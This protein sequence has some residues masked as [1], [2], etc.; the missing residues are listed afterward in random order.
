MQS[1]QFPFEIVLGQYCQRGA[2]EA[3]YERLLSLTMIGKKSKTISMFSMETSVGRIIFILQLFLSIVG[4]KMIN[5]FLYSLCI[6]SYNK[7]ICHHLLYLLDAG[8][9]NWM[10]VATN[11]LQI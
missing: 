6:F 8:M 9:I 5:T 10:M 2:R 3:T 7:L 4:P 11:L 1:I